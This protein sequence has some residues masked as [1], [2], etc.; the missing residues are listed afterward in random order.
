MPDAPKL[1]TEF[2]SWFHLLSRPEDYAEEST[3][4]HSVLTGA[5]ARPTESLLELGAGGGNNAMHLKQYFRLTL[6]DVSAAMLESSRKINPQCEHIVGDM[7][8]LRLGR[9]FDAVLIH[10][11][12][13]YML[14]EDNLRAAMQTAF[15]HCAPGGAVLIMPDYVRET[16]RPGVHHG[17]HDGDGRALRHFEWTFDPDPTDSTYTVDFVYMLREGNSPVR[18]E[19]ECHV[20]GIFSRDVWMNLLTEAGFNARTV[21]DPYG[22]AVFVGTRG[23]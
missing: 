6:T 2:A 20:Y 15:E 19:T 17:G 8:T 23:L 22:R 7:R 16:F 11:A 18:V 9:K 21:N 10:D 4:A 13:V 5:C 1:Y 14:S 3:F 12:I